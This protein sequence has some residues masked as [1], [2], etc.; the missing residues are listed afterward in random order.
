M[1]N[2][3]KIILVSTLAVSMLHAADTT[4]T[5]L[6]FQKDDDGNMNPTIFIPIYYGSSNQ[7]YSGIGYTST[8]LKEINTIDGFSDGKNALVSTSKDLK[9]NYFTYIASFSSFKI[10]LGVESTYSEVKNNEFGYIHD[11]SNLFGKGADYYIAF[12]ND[13]DLDIQRHAIATDIT[14]P[15]GEYF[16]SRLSTSVSPFTTISVKQFTNFK[17]LVMETGTSSSSTT[18][19]IAYNIKYEGQIHTGTFVDI[20]LVAN[21]DFQPLK[22]DIAQLAMKKGNYVFETN[23]IDTNEVTSSYIARLLF[24]YEVM[25]GLKPSIGFGKE[26]FERKDNMGGS[27]TSTDTNIIS[28]GFEK[29]F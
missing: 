26:H 2:L 20:G 16:T 27:T 29:R 10:S 6:S 12:D 13:I 14:I 17:P 23:T 21:Y 9:L 24:D 25:G 1:Q 28:V 15:M 4:K 8:N 18:Q 19:D 22:Y 3:K 5:E 7:F 11:S